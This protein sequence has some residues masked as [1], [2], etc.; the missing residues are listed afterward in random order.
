MGQERDQPAGC[1]QQ[2][3]KCS[4]DTSTEHNSIL[5]LEKMELLWP[6]ILETGISH[7]AFAPKSFPDPGGDAIG[8]LGTGDTGQ[9]G[10]TDCPGMQAC[11]GI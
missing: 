11:H 9:R 2:E 10:Q 8:S 6:L 1:R 7:P 3:L 4:A 5:Q